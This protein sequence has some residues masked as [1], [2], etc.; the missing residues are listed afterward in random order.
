MACCHYLELRKHFFWRNNNT[1]VYDPTRKVFRA[2]PKYALNG[3]PDIIVIKDG[4]FV[5]LEI[6]TKSG[7]QSEHQ[8][9]FERNCKQAGGEYHLITS[10]DQLK[11]IGL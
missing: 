2:M 7:R 9:E 11:E 4:W 8:K 1:P 5:G 6:K 3:V 10:V